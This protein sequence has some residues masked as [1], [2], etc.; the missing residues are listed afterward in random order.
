[1]A[2]SEQKDLIQNVKDLYA[3]VEKLGSSVSQV[4]PSIEEILKLRDQFENL[5]NQTLGV[6]KE[7]ESTLEN[8]TAEIDNLLIDCKSQFQQVTNDVEALVQLQVN[9]ESIRGSI[10]KCLELSSTLADLVKGP[11]VLMEGESIPIKDRVP[12]KHYL[13]VTDSVAIGG[14]GGS[15]DQPGIPS[16]VAVSPNMAISF[17]AP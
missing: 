17:D 14:A 6:I 3:Q 11:F 12:Y 10:V 16:T 5:S 13:K 4:E 7:Y 2:Y 1:M 15:G 9:F 8:K